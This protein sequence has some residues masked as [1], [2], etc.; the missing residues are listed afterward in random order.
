M[1]VLRLAFMNFRNSFRSYLSLVLSL[2]FTILILF[3]FQNLIYSGPFAVLGERNKQYIDMLV[4]TVSVVLGCFMFFFL[5]Y[6]TNVFLTRRKRE[7]GIYIFMGMSN[8]KIGRLYVIEISFVG[9][10]ALAAGIESGALPP[11]PGGAV[12]DDHERS[13]RYRG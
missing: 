8:R 1:R 10:T 13:V 12:S 2:A 3:N 11:C 7:I 4:E 6:A 9:V 5:W